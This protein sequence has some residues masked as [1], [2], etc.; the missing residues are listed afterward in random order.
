MQMWVE[1]D[2]IP[3]GLDG[4]DDAGDELPARQGLFAELDKYL[5]L[6]RKL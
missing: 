2:P 1:V 4:D 6:L 3:E 5:L